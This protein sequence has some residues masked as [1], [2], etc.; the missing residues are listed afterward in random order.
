MAVEYDIKLN[1][2]LKGAAASTC[3]GPFTVYDNYDK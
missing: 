2:N 3:C 1:D